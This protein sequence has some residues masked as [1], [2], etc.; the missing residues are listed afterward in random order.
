MVPTDKDD[1]FSVCYAQFSFG[2]GSGDDLEETVKD[3]ECVLAHGM[4]LL[5]DS[6]R[7]LPEPVSRDEAENM[8]Q[9]VLKGL[10]LSV[11]DVK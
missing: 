11:E 8:A 7:T 3:V 1:T 9:K 2:I 4:N 10:D 5:A 6:G